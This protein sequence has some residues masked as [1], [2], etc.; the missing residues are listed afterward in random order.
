MKNLKAISLISIIF[1]ATFSISS[2]CNEEIIP[3]A[4]PAEGSFSLSLSPDD[5]ETET[6]TRVGFDTNVSNFKLSLFD[7][8]SSA[9]FQNI[10]YGELSPEDCMLPAS[11]GYLL[12][13]ESCSESESILNNN[14][15]GQIRFVGSTEFDVRS[16]ENTDVAL[17]CSMVNAGLQVIFDDSF[18][19][20]FPIN[21]I[22]TQDVRSLTFNSSLDGSIAYYNLSNSDSMLLKL[23]LTGSIGGWEGRLDK[24]LEVTLVKG[25]ILRLVI[26]FS[27]ATG[28][29][30]GYI[31]Y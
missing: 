8:S 26:T 23:K 11:V 17:N 16:G 28:S 6:V 14:G 13:A 27:E 3:E 18:V 29:T 21:N 2:C 1:F 10:L 5:I 9:V 20:K 24:A 7:S 30:L 12:T 22:V 25:K 4:N 19:D 31:S 15:Y